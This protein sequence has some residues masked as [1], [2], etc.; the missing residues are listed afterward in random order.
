MNHG[1]NQAEP[2]GLSALTTDQGSHEVISDTGKGKE[3]LS[4]V[5]RV[6][7]ERELKQSGVQKMLVDRVDTLETQVAEL[8]SFRDKYHK[9]DQ[10]RA[11]LV[12]RLRFEGL[13]EI[14]YGALLVVG[15]LLIALSPNVKVHWA[16]WIPGT[17]AVIGAVVGKLYWRTRR[18]QSR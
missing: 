2:E 18:G 17:V 3:A 1:V 8:S 13:I 12:E 7:S 11:I 14:M 9:T 10:D 6:L 16:L 4:G 5:S 15:P